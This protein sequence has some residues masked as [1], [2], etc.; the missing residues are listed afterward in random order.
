M[1]SNSIRPT[2]GIEL[3]ILDKLLAP[4]LKA[5]SGEATPMDY[6]QS[7]PVYSTLFPTFAPQPERG[8]GGGGGPTYGQGSIEELIWQAPDHYDHLHFA[9]QDANLK[10]LARQL[11]RRGFEVGEL[12]G[13][14]GEGQVSGGHT[15]GSHHYSGNAMD[16][17]YYGG[18]RWKNENQALDWLNDFLLR[19]Y[20]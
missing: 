1:P 20:G 6:L 18:G 11:E 4:Y 3:A 15:E 12:E 13:F 5:Q 10:R 16:V 9:S 19:K 14:Q 17:N 8:R 7:D 2:T